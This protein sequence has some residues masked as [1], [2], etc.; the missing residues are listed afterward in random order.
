[1]IIRLINTVGTASYFIYVFVRRVL[2]ITHHQNLDFVVLD[3]CILI[4]L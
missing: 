3:K 1:M 4:N 2:F